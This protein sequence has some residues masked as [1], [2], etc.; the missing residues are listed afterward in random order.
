MW[1]SLLSEFDSHTDR[2]R[3]RA[4]ERRDAVRL[5]ATVLDGDDHE[6]VNEDDLLG[7]WQP[8]DDFQGDVNLRTLRALLGKI[9]ELGFE[10]CV[11]TSMH[12]AG[13]CAHVRVA[14]AGRHTNFSFI[15][16]SSAR[17]RV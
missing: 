9:D 3:Q 17:R 4:R 6:E 15:A 16:H 1:G 2:L 13:V 14:A 8:S 12:R 11:C 5:K 10:R 7:K